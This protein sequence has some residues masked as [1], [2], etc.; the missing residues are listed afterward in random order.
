M[1]LDPLYDK[2]GFYMSCFMTKKKGEIMSKYSDEDIRN[3]NK[4]TLQIAGTYLG[5]PGTAI[6][7]GMR[8]N[9]LPI[10]FAVHNEERDRSYSESW[11][12]HIVPERLIVYKYGKINQIQVDHIEKSLDTIIEEFRKMQADLSNLLCENADLKK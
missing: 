11:T 8:N 7:L 12:Y 3:L 6:A 2:A 10:G 5:I 1:N 9:Y 4:V